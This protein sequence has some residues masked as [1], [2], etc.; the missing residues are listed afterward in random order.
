LEGDDL[1]LK[2]FF[3]SV[4]LGFRTTQ[5]SPSTLE[6]D[7]VHFFIGVSFTTKCFV[8]ATMVFYGGDF[9]QSTD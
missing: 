8:G 1:F 7:V 9:A 2:S 6:G 5:S 3:V 4:A